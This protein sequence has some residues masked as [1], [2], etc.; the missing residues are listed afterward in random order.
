VW[1]MNRTL[2]EKANGNRTLINNFVCSVPG[3]AKKIF[4]SFYLCRP[5]MMSGFL[6]G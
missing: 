4:L 6:S 1:R 2:I 5:D 3:N